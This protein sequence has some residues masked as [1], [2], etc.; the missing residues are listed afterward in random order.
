[1]IIPPQNFILCT[2]TLVLYSYIVHRT[3]S[4]LVR[5]GGVQS[6]EKDFYSPCIL[7]SK[8][9]F[10]IPIPNTQ[11]PIPKPNTQYMYQ[12]TTTR[13][14]P[15]DTCILSPIY[16]L[17]NEQMHPNPVHVRNSAIAY[18][19]AITYARG[20]CQASTFRDTT[21]HKTIT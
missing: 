20:W 15:P 7:H 3:N 12:Y 10:P 5:G 11:Y 17:T 8:S 19:R 4:P 18:A 13:H 9:Q 21:D 6:S 2:R 16:S 14:P 1:M